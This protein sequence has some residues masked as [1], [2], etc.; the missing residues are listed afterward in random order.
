ML[1]TLNPRSIKKMLEK[2]GVPIRPSLR[3]IFASIPVFWI[4]AL[5][6]ITWIRPE[7][8]GERMLRHFMYMMMLEFWVI[9]STAFLSGV[10]LLPPNRRIKGGIFL[11]LTVLYTLI[12]L[13]IARDYGSA[14]PLWAFWGLTL[15]K[16][17]SFVSKCTAGGK[18]S[19]IW[20]TWMAMVLAYMV[21]FEIAALLPLPKLGITTEVLATQ[22]FQDSD[23][24]ARAHRY[25]AFG[26]VYFTLLGV[27]EMLCDNWFKAEQE[28]QDTL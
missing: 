18:N 11:A 2:T 20:Y 17:P 16:F 10:T 4:A 13:P 1:K 23:D 12:V 3:G 28:E 15:A 26:L 25:M 24:A 5:F 9:H 14:W 19:S 27:F 8:L 7:L 6:L 22:G 21:A